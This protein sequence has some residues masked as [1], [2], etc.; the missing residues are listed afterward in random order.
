MNHLRS[1][2]S[3]LRRRLRELKSFIADAHKAGQV[4]FQAALLEWLRRFLFYVIISLVIGL[5]VGAVIAF[6]GI[7]LER[8]NDLR[9]AHPYY[10]IPLLG[11]AG[12][13]IM[14]VYIKFSGPARR[15]MHML[16]DVGSGEQETIP[17]RTV[18]LTIFSTWTTHLFGGSAGCEGVAVQIGAAISMQFGRLVRT[19]LDR[20]V[21]L[22]CGMAAGISALFGT[23]LAGA[24]FA[25]EILV[26]GTLYY[27]ALVPAMVGAYVSASVAGSLG[28]EG[29]HFA[30]GYVPAMNLRFM[31]G[32]VACGLAFG[33]VG[34]AFSWLLNHLRVYFAIL[35]HNPMLR[36]A[37]IGSLLAV[38]FL[39]LDQGRYSGLSTALE[40]AT[41]TGETQI[42]PWD[43]F[44]K[45]ML[46]TISLSCGFQGGA[47]KPLFCIGATLG[48]VIAG[49][50][51]IP[52]GLCAA[53]GLIGVF[54]AATNTLITPIFLGLEIFGADA[55]PYF[56]IVCIVAFVISGR[57]GVFGGQRFMSGETV[58]KH[59][60][61]EQ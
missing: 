4:S 33:V 43:W 17:L 30:I 54:G 8:L 1:F 42:L 11:P 61:K 26:V 23:P 50:F 59:A 46:T 56:A 49:L 53:M 37:I 55:L 7:V 38:A 48:A 18:P 21:L 9:D 20:H 10:F 14:A 27:E 40:E 39:L 12:I 58:L 3:V 52:T 32:T 29:M 57:D 5:L 16:F 47:M 51:G 35:I 2:A 41:W 22:V 13:G 36:I 15:G 44:F 60:P 45:L 6:F 34:W 25:M 19:S 28:L 24:F 31:A